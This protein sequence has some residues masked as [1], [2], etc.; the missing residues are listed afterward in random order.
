LSPEGTGK[1]I[2]ADYALSRD[3]DQPDERTGDPTSGD[4]LWAVAA[5]VVVI[6]TALFA[7]DVALQSA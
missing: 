5:L 3:D 1:V 4:R 7:I 2:R 6:A